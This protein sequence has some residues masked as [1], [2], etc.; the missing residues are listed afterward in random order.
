MAEEM[1]KISRDSQF[2]LQGNLI[3]TKD[4]GNL[5]DY[6]VQLLSFHT[7]L[8]DGITLSELVHALYGMSKF[9]TDYFSEDYEVA[10]SFTTATKLDKNMSRIK[11]YKSFRME[12]D[13]FMDDDEYVY[14]LPEVKFEEAK[15]GEPGY[16]KLGNLPVVIDEDLI[17]KGEEFSFEK[18]VKFTLLD[19]MTCIF[20]EVVYTIK[21]GKNVEA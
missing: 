21:D 13:D 5:N 20:E 8:E 12:S 14:I 4:V 19:I 18:K 6:L 7:T 1:L 16:L 9:I 2:Y 10:R 3:S 15:E 17:Y 11:F